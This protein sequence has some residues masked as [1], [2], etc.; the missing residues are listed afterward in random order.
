M[1]ESKQ[2]K[3]ENEDNIA[4]SRAGL[5]DTRDAVLIEACDVLQ[6]TDRPA[7]FCPTPILVDSK[8]QETKRIIVFSKKSIL[9][10]FCI[11]YQT[12]LR[13]DKIRAALDY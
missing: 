7:L 2:R 13:S 5:N 6:Q 1:P 10:I 11:R 12:Q 3:D 9:K 4:L 8:P